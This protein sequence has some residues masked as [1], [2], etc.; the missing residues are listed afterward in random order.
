MLQNHQTAI[1]IPKEL[2]FQCGRAL[3]IP[4]MI[5]H[6]WE[7][8][9]IVW[10]IEAPPCNPQH[11]KDLSAGMLSARQHRITATHSRGHVIVSWQVKAKSITRWDFYGS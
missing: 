7:M 2:S 3:K 10:S 11:S 6:P 1:G 8:P 4:Q 9:E 5:E